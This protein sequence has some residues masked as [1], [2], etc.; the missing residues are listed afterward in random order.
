[1]S[2]VIYSMAQMGGADIGS[3]SYGFSMFWQDDRKQSSHH[4]PHVH[5]TY[6]GENVASISLDFPFDRLAPKDVVRIREH[7]PYVKRAKQC[8]AE[9]VG[10][11]HFVWDLYS[12]QFDYKV[13]YS[14]D[15]EKQK[16]YIQKHDIENPSR[17]F[18]DKLKFV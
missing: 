3:S 15:I 10:Y 2:E 11:W 18:G 17:A 13:G 1:M 5:L 7:L 8:V 4:L 9:D 12:K 14:G 16:R 6:N